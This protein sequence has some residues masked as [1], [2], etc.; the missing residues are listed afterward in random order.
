VHYVLVLG[1]EFEDQSL[2]LVL[3]RKPTVVEAVKRIARPEDVLVVESEAEAVRVA[4]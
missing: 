1:P 2:E 4:G 3:V